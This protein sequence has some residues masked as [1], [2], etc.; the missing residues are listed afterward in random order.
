MYRGHA[1]GA[2]RGMRL[3]T[4]AAVLWWVTA[5][6]YLLAALLIPLE[7]LPVGVG[8]RPVHVSKR[9][10]GVTRSVNTV[11]TNA[12]DQSSLGD[13]SVGGRTR[14][15]VNGYP[16]PYHFSNEPYHTNSGTAAPATFDRGDGFGSQSGPT[17]GFV[18]YP[19]SSSETADTYTSVFSGTSTTGSQFLEH[20]TLMQYDHDQVTAGVEPVVVDD[21]VN[22]GSGGGGVVVHTDQTAELVAESIFASGGSVLAPPGDSSAIYTGTIPTYF[23]VHSDPDTAIGGSGDNNSSSQHAAVASP[24]GGAGNGM[25]SDSAGAHNTQGDNEAEILAHSTAQQLVQSES[26]AHN[27]DNGGGSVGGA[28]VSG[29]VTW[30]AKLVVDQGWVDMDSQNMCTGV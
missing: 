27:D 11:L 5:A 18:Y 25:N 22:I 20:S 15:I 24:V 16:V 1:T 8:A 10:R 28:A 6:L 9:G 12:D 26:G 21:T 23:H 30:V 7:P 14:R 4:S 13:N 19:A 17:T 2:A 3:R 29:N